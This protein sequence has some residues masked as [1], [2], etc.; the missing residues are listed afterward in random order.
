MEKVRLLISKTDTCIGYHSNDVLKNGEQHVLAYLTVL[1]EDRSF[2]LERDRLMDCRFLERSR[3]ARFLS[4]PS[5]H[6][7]AIASS[8]VSRSE[9]S[10]VRS[11]KTKSWASAHGDGG[12][13]YEANSRM[14]T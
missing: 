9:G 4:M 1:T 5:S 8:A 13:T 2:L 3:S 6:G 11:L 12:D 7:W 14:D 10:T